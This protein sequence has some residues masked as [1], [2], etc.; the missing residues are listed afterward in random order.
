MR[1]I[2]ELQEGSEITEKKPRSEGGWCNEGTRE[3]KERGRGRKGEEKGRLV[4]EGRVSR[5]LS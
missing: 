1:G 3:G 5:V 4:S 2:S